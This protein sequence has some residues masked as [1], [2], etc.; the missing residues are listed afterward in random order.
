MDGDQLTAASRSRV[1]L[2]EAG[3]QAHVLGLRVSAHP[4]QL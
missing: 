4:L 1:P 3:A 2:Q